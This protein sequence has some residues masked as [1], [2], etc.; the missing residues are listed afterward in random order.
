MQRPRCSMKPPKIRRSTVPRRRS[1]SIL[2][3]AML[4]VTLP[5]AFWSSSPLPPPDL[6]SPDAGGAA[7]IHQS[8]EQRA[9]Q[10]R[11]L[12]DVQGMQFVGVGAQVVDFHVI[13][14]DI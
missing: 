6:S 3:L 10:V 2:I 14:A 13:L 11:V 7:G 9:H 5:L 12:P 8:A 1:T 4:R